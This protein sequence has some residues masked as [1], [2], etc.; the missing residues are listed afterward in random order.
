MISFI[1][2]GSVRSRSRRTLCSGWIDASLDSAVVIW[3]WSLQG[4]FVVLSTTQGRSC[5]SHLWVAG[6]PIDFGFLRSGVR[7]LAPWRSAP[8]H[9]LRVRA[10]HDWWW[11]GGCWPHTFIWGGS[12]CLGLRHYLPWV[13]QRD[14]MSL[15]WLFDVSHRANWWLLVGKVKDQLC[16][17][18]MPAPPRGNGIHQRLRS[19][20]AAAPAKGASR[21]WFG[22]LLVVTRWQPGITL[23]FW[24]SDWRNFSLRLPWVRAPSPHSHEVGGA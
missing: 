9:P 3:N 16:V 1:S 7:P 21:W 12:L 10:K 6:L 8:H 13:M 14:N 24:C 2:W 19:I 17:G 15:F 5:L 11:S 23:V 4:V 22:S 20:A 18:W